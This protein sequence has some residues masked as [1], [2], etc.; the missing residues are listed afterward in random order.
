MLLNNKKRL[1]IQEIIRRISLDKE[2]S[3]KE[4]V[5]IEKFAKHNST[6]SLWL[7]KANSIRR[8]GVQSEVSINGLLQS[9][10]IDGLDKESHFNPSK[11]DISDWFG[12]SP[13]WI[14]RS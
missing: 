14:K 4:R 9:M 11:D 12:N 2:V 3:F 10:G 13:D 5:Y 6:I 8:H 7:K 1:K